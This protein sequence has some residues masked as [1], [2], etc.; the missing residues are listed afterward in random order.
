MRLQIPRINRLGYWV[1]YTPHG[2]ALKWVIGKLQ[3]WFWRDAPAWEDIPLEIRLAA[4]AHVFRAV[5]EH[6]RGGGTYRHLIYERLGFDLDAY[7]PLY[8]AGGMTI[9][10][11]FVLGHGDDEKD[12]ARTDQ[13]INWEA[14]CRDRMVVDPEF[15]KWMANTTYWMKDRDPGGVKVSLTVKAP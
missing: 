6:A 8:E 11:D 12:E 9:S 1:W 4:T 7:G 15:K 2:K 13:S 5:C 10:N 14:M 3:D